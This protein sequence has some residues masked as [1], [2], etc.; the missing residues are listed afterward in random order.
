MIDCYGYCG[1]PLSRGVGLRL[2]VARI[3]V[4]DVDVTDLNISTWASYTHSHFTTHF[5]G[6]AYR[7]S[8]SRGYKRSRRLYSKEL[9]VHLDRTVDRLSLNSHHGLL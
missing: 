3:F 9:H 2:S 5:T 1:C 4:Y 6:V 8:T 7:V